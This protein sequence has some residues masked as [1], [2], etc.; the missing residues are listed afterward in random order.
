MKNPWQ[1]KDNNI[2]CETH[3]PIY[4][5]YIW[6][7][8][9]NDKECFLAHMWDAMSIEGN[10][11]DS[12]FSDCKSKDVKH[13]PS[14]KNVTIIEWYKPED[15]PEE[16]KDGRPLLVKRFRKV[17]GSVHKEV[18]KYYCGMEQATTVEKVADISHT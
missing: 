18:M 15:M 9:T 14:I 12:A 5:H 3:C 10:S 11:C 1:N 2:C 6:L 17:F 16:W 13:E 4:K 7:C 8:N